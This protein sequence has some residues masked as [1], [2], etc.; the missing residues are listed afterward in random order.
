MRATAPTRTTASRPAPMRSLRL[1]SMP[2]Q[3]SRVSGRA[4]LERAI[5][6]VQDRDDRRP[7][8][9][10]DRGPDP[11]GRVAGPL[12]LDAPVLAG[13]GPREGTVSG[14]LEGADVVGRD[15]GRIGVADVEHGA[16]RPLP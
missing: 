15:L 2:P 7:A 13:I 10:A 6:P 16:R 12:G 8:E 14:R 1:G 3:L 5:R 11:A 9:G 4:S